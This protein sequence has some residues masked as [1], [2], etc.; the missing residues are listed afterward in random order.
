MLSGPEGQAI[1]E[2]IMNHQDPSE[3]VYA[4]RTIKE[5]GFAHLLS[6]P[7]GQ[8]IREAIIK[9][10]DP[11]RLASALCELECNGL[12]VGPEGHKNREAVLKHSSPLSIAFILSPIHKAGLLSGP[13][14][15]AHRV[16]VRGH[17][18]PGQ[19]CDAFY[20]YDHDRSGSL[21]NPEIQANVRALIRHIDPMGL[22]S[23]FQSLRRSHEFGDLSATDEQTIREIVIKSNRPSACANACITQKEQALEASRQ[24]LISSDASFFSSKKDAGTIDLKTVEVRP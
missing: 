11:A 23:A 12:L 1:F 6:G 18:E 14:G 7:E 4:M 24:A 3:F 19:L 22:E 15:D 17:Q 16:M 10:E 13:E 8:I 5:H 21:S 9:H 20:R 2:A